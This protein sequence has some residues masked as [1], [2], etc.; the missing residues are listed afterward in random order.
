MTDYAGPLQGAIVALAAGDRGTAKA[1]LDPIAG[2]IWTDRFKMR[3]SAQPASTTPLERAAKRS[4]SIAR[5]AN[6]FTR[7]HFCCVYCEKRVVA[8]AVA[9]LLHDAFPEAIPY[10]QRYKHGSMHPLFWTN[11][12]EADHLVPGAGGGSWLELSNHVTACSHCN[13]VKSD[14]PAEKWR[15]GP[16]AHAWDGLV[17]HYRAAW[18]HAGRPRE[19]YHGSWIRALERAAAARVSNVASSW[20]PVSAHHS[21]Q[22]PPMPEQSE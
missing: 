5:S 19:K 22:L 18:D 8:R 16:S 2:Q 10:N 6:T 1:A 14:A 7:D 3:S 4:F 11:V 15:I 9:V 21:D 13:A 12:A 17:S 20:T